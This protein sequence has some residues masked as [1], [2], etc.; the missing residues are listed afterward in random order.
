[1]H[2]KMIALLVGWVVLIMGGVAYATTCPPTPTP[3]H[4]YSKPPVPTWTPST[5]H[6]Q[7]SIPIITHKSTY[8]APSTSASSTSATPTL[9]PTS[10][11]VGVPVITL[12]NCTNP[13]QGSVSFPATPDSYQYSLTGTGLISHAAQG[14][15]LGFGTYTVSIVIAPGFVASGTDSWTFTFA[16]VTG[17][18]STVIITP[19]GNDTQLPFTGASDIEWLTA[20]SSVMLLL[21]TLFMA[22]SRRYSPR[23]H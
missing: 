7:P 6:T 4:S 2:N 8:P 9:T 18:T 22:R 14:V 10:V 16:A 3:T 1:M 21:G 20:I 23:S 17:C 13:D 11:V 19:V 5:H 12:P 15:K